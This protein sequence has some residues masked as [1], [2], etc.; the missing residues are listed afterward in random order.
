MPTPPQHRPEPGIL[1]GARELPPWLITRYIR[2]HAEAMGADDLMI[3]LQDYDQRLLVPITDEAVGEPATGGQ[4]IEGTL[5]GRC[6]AAMSPLDIIEDDGRHRLFLPLIDGGER[7]GVLT[8]A[9]LDA[10]AAEG[11]DWV[12]FASVVTAL[13]VA[14]GAHTD[15]YFRARRR[16]DMSLAA[17][18]QWHLLPP[19]AVMDPR[20]ALAGVV[21]PAYDVGGDAF[22]YAINH[23]TAHIAVFD[24]MGHGLDAAVMAG[25]AV[26]AYRHGRRAG[27]PVEDLYTLIDAEF[28][29]QFPNDRFVTAQLANLDLATGML[30]L[31]NAGH[32]A[33]LHIRGHRVLGP[34][35]GTPA[36]P[37]GLNEPQP[38]V[39]V[40][41]LEAGDLLLFYTDGVV[42]ARRATGTYGDDRFIADIEHVLGTD[43]PLPE[44]VRRLNHR[45]V[46]WRGGEPDDDATIVLAQWRSRDLPMP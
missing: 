24:A 18:M 22:D 2:R 29:R 23:E 1:T 44:V 12:E 9:V 8:L 28:S 6:F 25:V 17:E 42:E 45:L 21:E 19:L 33:P 13:L 34:I 36:L 20:L 27:I 38:Q 40:R 11:T 10:A 39:I 46:E 30:T 7:V 26:G 5:A 16:K 37:I 32:P 31:V 14:K 3:M 15:V 43:L 35:T 41:N 4:A